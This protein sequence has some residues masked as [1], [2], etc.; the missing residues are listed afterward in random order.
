MGSVMRVIVERSRRVVVRCPVE[1]WRGSALVHAETEDIS[2]HGAFVRSEEFFPRGHV[3]DLQFRMPDGTYARQ[4]A[5]VAHV[6]PQGIAK[7]IGRQAGMGFEFYGPTCEQILSLLH[8]A[9]KELDVPAPPEPRKLSI[10]VADA[11]LPLFERLATILEPA[12]H[13]ILTATTGR[14][15]LE[16]CRAS[17]P[18]VA[19]IDVD[20]EDMSAWELLDE[21]SHDPALA[22]LHVGV[23]GQAGDDISRLRAY[24][25]GATDF[26]QK[27]FTD[28]EIAVRI[29]RLAPSGEVEAPRPALTGDLAALSL[30]T[31]LSMFDFDHKSGTLCI[32]RK[33]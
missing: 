9:E 28:E 16:I 8:G 24:R 30:A 17:R 31:L 14:R 33:S 2:E 32:E 27:P 6:L 10:L 1:F 15:A 13:R 26:I 21:L 4:R 20:L 25:R 19:L 11:S 23:M 5:S 3:L 18:D 29:G 12:G 22:T 7:T